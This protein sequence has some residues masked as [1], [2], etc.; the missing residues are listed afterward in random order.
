VQKT[1]K[2]AKTFR[3]A[4]KL[5]VQ[6]FTASIV[7]SDEATLYLSGNVNRHNQRV[8]RSNN[9]YEVSDR[10]RAQS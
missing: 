7:F 3:S 5:E 9:S 8:W 6:I 4:F 2:F 10:I 1:T